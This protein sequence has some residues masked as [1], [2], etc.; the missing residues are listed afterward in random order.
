M[1]FEDNLGVVPPYGIIQYPEKKFV[2]EY[3]KT[4]KDQIS[5][6]LSKMSDYLDGLV[7][8]FPDKNKLCK[9][10]K[11]SNSLIQF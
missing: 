11:L 2:V 3:T 9:E 10:C 7:E 1:L 8:F 4:N 5:Q 6:T